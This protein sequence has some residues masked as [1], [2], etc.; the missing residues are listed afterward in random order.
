M[1]K[2]CLCGKNVNSASKTGA[3]FFHLVSGSQTQLYVGIP[4]STLKNP[5]V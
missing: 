1:F 3:L 5:D 2:L 4:R